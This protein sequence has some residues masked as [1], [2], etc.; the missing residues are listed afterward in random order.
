[1]P[2]TLLDMTDLQHPSAQEVTR[3]LYIECHRVAP[4][5]ER[6]GE[7]D[8]VLDLMIH[9]IDIIQGL[10][11]LTATGVHAVGTQVITTLLR[12]SPMPGSCSGPPA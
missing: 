5:K 8:V 6:G 2:P 1:M 11:G 7:V 10:V 9:D 4:W 12:T 3:P